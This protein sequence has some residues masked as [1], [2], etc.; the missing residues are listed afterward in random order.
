MTCPD[1][2]QD[3][4]RPAGPFDE[5]RLSAIAAMATIGWLI[6]TEDLWAGMVA[7]TIL[8]FG[9]A[10]HRA[11]R[12]WKDG[13]SASEHAAC[14][15][16]HLADDPASQSLARRQRMGESIALRAW[17]ASLIGLVCFPPLLLYS[18]WLLVRLNPKKT[19][20]GVAGTL[21]RAAAWVISLNGILLFGLTFFLVLFADLYYEISL[22][23]GGY[24]DF[25]AVRSFWP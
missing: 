21:R 13:D 6:A 8:A 23:F 5:S 16:P 3:A 24:F 25:S 11:T 9:L 20:L 1:P 7:C 22:V 10:V 15:E 17:R 12:R 4:S 18:T 14:E 19:P 2:S